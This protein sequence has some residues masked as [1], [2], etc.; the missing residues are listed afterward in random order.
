MFTG[1]IR[2]IAT[3]KSYQNNILTIKSKHP[4]KLGDSIAI[5]GV[6]L[7]VIKLHSDGFDLE[8]AESSFM[9][10]YCTRAK[11]KPIK[12]KSMFTSFSGVSSP[13]SPVFHMFSLSAKLI[14]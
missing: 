10:I 9:F 12:Y 7:T 11:C 4:A 3:V 13:R 2:E 1:L 5:N 8:L 14:G 6:C